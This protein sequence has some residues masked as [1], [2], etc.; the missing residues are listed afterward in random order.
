[1]HMKILGYYRIEERVELK[2]KRNGLL[3]QYCIFFC[4]SCFCMTLKMLQDR[5]IDDHGDE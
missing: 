5:Q 3:E 4:F 2:K 1:M